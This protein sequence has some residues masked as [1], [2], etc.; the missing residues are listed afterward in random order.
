MVLGGGCAFGF[1][2]TLPDNLICIYLNFQL[3]LPF[4]RPSH[5]P[6]PVFSCPQHGAMVRPRGLSNTSS[7]S[8]VP[9]QDQV[10]F[11]VF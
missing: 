1:L 10:C 2:R 6:I 7:A 4:S 9:D 3:S 11:P 5:S 8:S